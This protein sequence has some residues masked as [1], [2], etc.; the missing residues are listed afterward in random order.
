MSACGVSGAQASLFRFLVNVGRTSEQAL[1]LQVAALPDYFVALH[2]VRS[3]S[4]LYIY[5]RD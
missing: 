4:Y 5:I 3:N 2:D 1:S